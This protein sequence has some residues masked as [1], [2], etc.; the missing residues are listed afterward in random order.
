MP[1]KNILT[2]IIF[3]AVCGL[4]FFV[5]SAEAQAA[6]FYVC[7]SATTCNAGVGDGWST[8]SDSHTTAQAQNKSTPYLT[9]QKC[10]DVMAPGDTCIVGDGV[11]TDPNADGYVV[12]ISYPSRGGSVGLP[13]TIQTENKWGALIDCG[14]NPATA[15][16]TWPQSQNGHENTAIRLTNN[17]SYVTIDGFEI[18][19]CGYKALTS[20][21]DTGYDHPH[22][23]I[24]KNNWVHHI[25]GSAISFYNSHDNIFD[26]NII[27]DYGY[28]AYAE[29][30]GGGIGISG[31][32]LTVTNNIIYN[33]D[34]SNCLAIQFKT[35][36]TGAVADDLLY[37]N[38]NWNVSNNVFGPT[39]ANCTSPAKLLIWGRHPNN[40]VDNNIFYGSKAGISCYQSPILENFTMSNNIMPV[41][42]PL[43][44]SSCLTLGTI[45]E[46]GTI[47]GDP[48][49]VDGSNHI[50]T[51][52]S[53]SIALNSGIATN[54]PNHDILGVLRPQGS[55]Y[56]IGAYEYNGGSV[57]NPADINGDSKVNI[58]DIQAC[59]KVITRSNLTYENQCRVLAPPEITT[60]IK[61]IQVIIRAII[62]G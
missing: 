60:N 32:N 2:A 18:A 47:N 8:G 38:S 30:S 13:V 41:G 14:N 9:I 6:T 57:F 59:I 22:N 49:F 58:K 56:D 35:P 28:P 34:D 10:V 15:R 25:R 1:R 21:A 17:A 55:G 23:V 54:A 26:S 7:N 33:G 46:S 3:L 4:G 40:T 39:T 45:I 27:H 62:G 20:G 36:N 42:Y 19:Y 50:Y 31:T 52:T 48:A 51:L 61:D 29:G 12:L 37:K 11:Q 44:H 16:S 5:V 53:T 43:L 24:F